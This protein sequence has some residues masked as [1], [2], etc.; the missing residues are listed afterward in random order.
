MLT[1][2]FDLGDVLVSRT[3]QLAQ[4]AEL[5]GVAIGHAQYWAP[6]ARYDAGISD[7]EYWSQVFEPFGTP[8]DANLAATLG[9][10]DAEMW[11]HIR[12]EAWAILADLHR[13][14][15]SIHILS[16][17]P[18]SMGPAIDRSPWRTFIGERFISG[19]L[20]V[21]KPHPGIYDHVEAALGLPPS[22]LAFIDDR[23]DNLEVPA[24]RG[25]TTHL[26]VSDADTRAWLETLGMLPPS[27]D[28]V[29]P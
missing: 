21:V 5:T 22:D 14:G 27:V 15:T 9:R 18:A 26:W 25:W 28:D 7:L 4:V 11:A 12:P 17:A 16:N 24:S 20:G 1:V 29:A 10:A 6:R 3:D 23:P 13:A 19:E 2:V 8:M